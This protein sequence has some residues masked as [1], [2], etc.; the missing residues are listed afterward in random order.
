MASASTPED[1]IRVQQRLADVEISDNDDDVTLDQVVFKVSIVRVQLTWRRR[2]M[3]KSMTSAMRPKKMKMTMKTM[4]L[5]Q[6]I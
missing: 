2:M 5:I 4:G 6:L 1:T 3:L